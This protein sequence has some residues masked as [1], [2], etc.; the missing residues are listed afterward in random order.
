MIKFVVVF[1]LFVVLIYCVYRFLKVSADVNKYLYKNDY[2]YWKK[3]FYGEDYIGEVKEPKFTF[4]NL[5]YNSSHAFIMYWLWGY[6]RDEQVI[7]M[8]NKGL[9]WLVLSA[10]LFITD[11]CLLLII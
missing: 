2:E 6:D 8:R 1:I 11:C 9:K 3:C 5:D 10:V 4:F 7:G